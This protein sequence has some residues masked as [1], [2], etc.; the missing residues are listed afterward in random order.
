MKLTSPGITRRQLLGAGTLIAVSSS[1]THAATIVGGEPL[2]WAPNAADPP[3]DIDPHNWTFFT[4]H[5]QQLVE[6]IVETLIPAD[7]MSMSGK[8]AGCAIY[9]DRQMSG[10]QGQGARMYLQG[11]FAKGLPTQGPQS[12][13]TPAEQMRAGLTSLEK[14]CQ[15]AFGK[16]FAQLSG[17]DR[18][19]LLSGL[20]S[21]HVELPDGVQGAAFFEVLL[22]RTM[23][24]FFAD[25]IYGGNRDM[26]SWKMIGY[27]GA[28]YDYLDWID[29]HGQTYP[30]PPVSIS[31]RPDWKV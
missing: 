21:G 30:N 29:K 6:A 1:F 2:P 5:E 12:P 23:E 31:G 17:H 25:P 26:V 27:P 14:H 28:R 24:G 11:P 22:S 19:A 20:E 8:E 7:D 15:G 16:T 13:L 3:A 10:P 9:I 18:E 4:E